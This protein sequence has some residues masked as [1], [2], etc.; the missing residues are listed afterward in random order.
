MTRPEAHFDLVATTKLACILSEKLQPIARRPVDIND[1]NWEQQALSMLAP[2][3]AGIRQEAE[4]L[5]RRILTGHRERPFP[6]G[7]RTRA[8]AWA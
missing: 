3:E 6:S 4:G 2:D 1:P 8:S 5:L 7:G